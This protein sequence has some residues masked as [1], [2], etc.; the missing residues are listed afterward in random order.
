MI[1]VKNVIFCIAKAKIDDPDGEFFPILLGTDRLI[2]LFGILRTMVGNDANV[3]GLIC[4]S[5][6]LN[7]PV[8]QR[9]QIFWLDT[10]T[11]TVHL[12]ASNLMHLR[13]NPRKFQTAPTTSNLLRGEETLN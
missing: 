2:E 8:L 4:C 11:G 9:S 12:D 5:S 13:G 10:L 3:Q 1:M 7:L 6:F